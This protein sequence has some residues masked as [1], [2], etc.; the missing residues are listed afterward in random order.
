VGI[1]KPF[2]SSSPYYDIFFIE[3]MKR[4]ISAF[5][6]N[7]LFSFFIVIFFTHELYKE[8]ERERE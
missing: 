3:A 8:R 5:E 6:S 2:F 1:K 4:F 7:A